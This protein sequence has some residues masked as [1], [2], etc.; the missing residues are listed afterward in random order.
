MLLATEVTF[1]FQIQYIRHSQWNLGVPD[2]HD[3]TTN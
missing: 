3:K 1:N 2:V